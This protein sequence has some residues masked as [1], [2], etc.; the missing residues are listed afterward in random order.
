[1]DFMKRY[2]LMGKY[3]GVRK[4]CLN[5]K[6]GMIFSIRVRFQIKL[7]KVV[8]KLKFVGCKIGNWFFGVFCKFFIILFNYGLLVS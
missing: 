3:R 6:V 8:V 4:V 5:Y 1:M 2:L 7:V